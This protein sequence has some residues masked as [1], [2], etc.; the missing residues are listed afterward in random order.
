MD[1]I[2]DWQTIRDH[3]NRSFRSNFHMSVA[4]VDEKGQPT[5]TPIGSLFLKDNQTGFYFEKYPTKLRQHA[6]VNKNICVLAV[7]S[8]TV[9]WL[10]SLFKGR[11]NRYPAIKLYGEL[12]IRR[13]ASEKEIKRL[14]R[15]MRTTK[16]LRGNT[17]LWGE[18]NSVREVTFNSAEKINLGQMTSALK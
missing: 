8:S 2:T 1:I 5:V 4:S 7:D 11:F 10:K 13:E 6:E 15:R 16:G 9:F 14:N 12:G 18:M 17:Y 3:F